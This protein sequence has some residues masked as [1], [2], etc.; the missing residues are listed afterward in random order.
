MGAAVEAFRSPIGPSTVLVFVLGSELLWGDCVSSVKSGGV[1]AAEVSR[2]DGGERLTCAW[3]C[4]WFG[5]S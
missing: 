4:C 2:C 3:V 1:G 5:P